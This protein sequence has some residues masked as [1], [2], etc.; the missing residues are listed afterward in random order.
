MITVLIGMTMARLLPAATLGRAYATHA[1]AGLVAVAAC[2]WLYHVALREASTPGWLSATRGPVLRAFVW[3]AV[4]LALLVFAVRG[5]SPVRSSSGLLLLAGCAFAIGVSEYHIALL[6]N[7]LGLARAAAFSVFRALVALVVVIIM[8]LAG[9]GELV[10][11]LGFAIG[12]VVAVAWARTWP[13]LRRVHAEPGPG[14]E[15][16]PV[17]ISAWLSFG[18]PA[19]GA[20]LVA[21]AT[22][23]GLR[24]GLGLGGQPAHA[25]AYALSS[26]LVT[27]LIWGIAS[28]L[29][30]VLMPMIGRVPGT[31]LSARHDAGMLIQ[32]SSALVA[33]VLIAASPVVATILAPAHLAPAVREALPWIAA[34]VSLITMRHFGVEFSNYS[35]GIGRGM[36]VSAVMTFAIVAG[37]LL[38]GRADS[39][40]AAGVA[41]TIGALGGLGVSLISAHTTG[42]A[43]RGTAGLLAM[44]GVVASA[45]VI[46]RVGW[47]LAFLVHSAVAAGLAWATLQSYRRLGAQLGPG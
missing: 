37:L 40:S 20:Q 35:G 27:L 44:L 34:G 36:F 4:F 3:S 38:T 23:G 15:T 12:G 29:V 39:A 17:R 9:T 6:R 16:P 2:G 46:G 42:A 26:D 28:T 32:A 8:I 25:G 30:V 47:G 5:F 21:L 7:T 45:A 43:A 13:A 19:A 10:L 24:V 33:V 18:V 22:D 14:P 41:L 11:A 31:H 1:F